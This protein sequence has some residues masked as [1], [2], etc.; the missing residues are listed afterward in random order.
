MYCENSEYLFKKMNLADRLKK[1]NIMIITCFNS[2]Q[3]LNTTLVETDF[4]A[5]GF[6]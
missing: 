4:V 3:N 5:L 6:S 1:L 2:N